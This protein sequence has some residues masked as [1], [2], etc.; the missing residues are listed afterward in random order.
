[1]KARNDVM[2]EYMVPVKADGSPMVNWQ[3]PEFVAAELMRMDKAGISKLLNEECY[4]GTPAYAYIE[5]LA[6]REKNNM[7]AIAIYGLVA[8]RRWI[9]DNQDALHKAIEHCRSTYSDQRGV[10][11]IAS[12][13]MLTCHKDRYVT[14]IH[15]FPHAYVNLRGVDFRKMYTADHKLSKVNLEYANLRE[16]NL[17]GVELTGTNLSFACL[18][19]AVLHD[20]H[21]ANA[22]LQHADL[23]LA[24]FTGADLRCVN[25]SSACLR[26]ANLQEAQ[27]HGANLQKADLRGANLKKARLDEWHHPHYY[28][29]MIPAASMQDAKYN[30]QTKLPLFFSPAR[31]D[32][33][34]IRERES[35]CIAICKSA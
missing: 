10:C 31:N 26:R 7:V 9:L 25:L 4:P 19:G 24:D 20:A 11:F 32:M 30:R 29:Q 35:R 21:L 17:S 8:S 27:L 15:Q 13:M 18:R 23:R 2:M 14:L 33:L 1:M 12:L 34:K 16:A 3:A 28:D 5:N 6:I 22:K